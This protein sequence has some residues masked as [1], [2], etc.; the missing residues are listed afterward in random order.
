MACVDMDTGTPFDTINVF[1]IEGSDSV[2][3]AETAN[4]R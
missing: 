2:E 3:R 1:D 4:V